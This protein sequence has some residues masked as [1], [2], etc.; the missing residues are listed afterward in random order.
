MNEIIDKVR[1][2]QKEAL[3]VIK[4]YWNDKEENKYALIKMPTGSGK[5]GVIACVQFW[6]TDIDNI[7]IVVPNSQLPT[8]IEFEIKEGFWSKIGISNIKSEF[9]IK[10]L[11]GINSK[12]G[13]ERKNIYIIT[14]Q[15]MLSIWREKKELYEQLKKNIDLIIFDEG[16]REPSKKWNRV[17]TQMNKKVVLFTATPYRND[18]VKFNITEKPKYIYT[19]SYTQAMEKGYIKSVEFKSFPDSLK[20]S[21]AINEFI[22]F[23]IEI[24][25]NKE[26]MV[27]R[28]I[29]SENI[30]MIVKK[31][32]LAVGKDISIGFHSKFEKDKILRK[33]YL[34]EDNDVFDIFVHENILIEGID[35]KDVDI[36]IIHEDFGNS[37]SIVQQIGRILRKKNSVDNKNALVYVKESKINRYRDQWKSFKKYDEANEDNI[38]YIDGKYREEFAL[39]CNFYNYIKLVKTANVYKGEVIKAKEVIEL[40][41]ENLQNNNIGYIEKKLNNSWICCYEMEKNSDILLN[42]I[43]L[44]KTLEYCVVVFIHNMIFYYDSWG[45]SFNLDDLTFN[46]EKVDAEIILNLFDERSSFKSVKMDRLNVSNYGKTNEIIK[47]NY[48]E[49]INYSVTENLVACTSVEGVID[50]C[51]RYISTKTSKINDFEKC[52]ISEYMN[53]A[54]DIYGLIQEGKRNNYFSRYAKM[55]YRINE[56]EYPTSILLT[57]DEGSIFYEEDGK[58]YEVNIEGFCYE[59]K[60]N[61]FELDLESEKIKCNIKIE[62]KKRGIKI[63]INLEKNRY[64]V[65]LSD[66][67]IISLQ[68]YIN[69]NRFRVLFNSNLFYLNGFLYKP[70]VNYFDIDLLETSLGKRIK[71]IKQLDNVDD[72]KEGSFKKTNKKSDKDK[73]YIKE[74]EEWDKRSVFGVL[75]D[76]LDKTK[77]F[78]YIVCDDLDTEIADFI[79]ISE[80]KIALIHCKYSVNKLSASAFQ[81]A[82]GQALKNLSY[83]SVSDVESN[84]KYI[85]KHIERWNRTWKGSKIPRIYPNDISG[86]V[87]W[88]KYKTLLQSTNR[89]LEVW[90]FGNLMSY[91]KLKCNLASSNPTEETKQIMWLLSSTD[92][93]ISNVGATLKIFCNE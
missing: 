62:N 68:E 78:K 31:I 13:K 92:E 71:T 54:E 22:K 85:A 4:S 44:E 63:R 42:K 26:K 7:L 35:M 70:N 25:K 15:G 18:R 58:E 2:E 5:T 72:E 16:H 37:R 24:Y 69:Y 17:I 21:D 33:N 39:D 90:I 11:K 77:E 50:Q 86:E 20:E 64:S 47:G 40:I 41:K 84:N 61:K 59:I 23:I 93:M 88:Q 38:H 8:Q 29:G 66:G 73:E 34:K 65:K 75:I 46:V 43:Y 30:E 14:V 53:W 57:I 10:V 6:L 27:I 79:A 55:Y 81:D 82:V 12:L 3:G 49:K 74:Y 83:L 45:F 36:L 32:N 89:E 48:L 1:E 80:K 76:Y 56:W 52:T 28:T 9:Q 51:N 19:L 87:F 67:T 91:E 60:E